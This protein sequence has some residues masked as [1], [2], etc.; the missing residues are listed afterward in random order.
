M[1]K[2]TIDFVRSDKGAR[3]SPCGKYRYV[4]WRIWER[5]QN[6]ALP[7]AMCIGLNPSTANASDDDPTIRRLTSLLKSRGYGGFYMTNLFALISPYPE[8]LRTCPDP[9]AQN[10]FWLDIVFK[11]SDD[12]IFCWGNFPMAA[13]I[14]IP[15]WCD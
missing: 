13:Y 4:L 14:S 3:F 2:E 9:V 6:M 5:S 15:L 11:K 7:M 12:V 1:S 8:D 10:D